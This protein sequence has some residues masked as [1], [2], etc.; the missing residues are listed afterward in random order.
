M[1]VFTSMLIGMQLR[2]SAGKQTHDLVASCEVTKTCFFCNVKLIHRLP[3]GSVDWSIGL[4][5]TVTF[6]VPLKWAE[7]PATY[8]QKCISP[9]HTAPLSWMTKNG[10]IL[11]KND[12]PLWWIGTCFSTSRTMCHGQCSSL[13]TKQQNTSKHANSYNTIIATFS[14]TRFNSSTAR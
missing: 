6:S 9:F 12:A 13:D 11:N 10:W 5:F 7:M 4:N 8:V 14:P 2:F 3:R 1:S